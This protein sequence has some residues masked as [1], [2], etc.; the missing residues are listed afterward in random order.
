MSAAASHWRWPRSAG[1]CIGRRLVRN[2][3][4]REEERAA[5]RE[6]GPAGCI[7]D[8]RDHARPFDA[9]DAEEAGDIRSALERSGK[10]IGPYDLLIATQARRRG[11]ILV[12]ANEREFTR[13]PGLSVENWGAR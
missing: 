1:G 9:D 8:A 4:R 11:A 13:V 10:P 2:L 3:V 5:R 6:R 12:T 7:P